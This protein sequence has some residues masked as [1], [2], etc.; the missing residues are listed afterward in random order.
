MEKY[1]SN[2]ELKNL[3][4]IAK[5]T[6]EIVS[7]YDILCDLET[8]GKKDSQSYRLYL[9]NLKNKVLIERDMYA[10]ISKSN[11][12]KYID[13][14]SS[15]CDNTY[16]NIDFMLKNY[17][18]RDF[19][20][21]SCLRIMW[22][23]KQREIFLGENQNKFQKSVLFIKFGL[24][25]CFSIL[26][27]YIDNCLIDNEK[28]KLIYYKYFVSYFSNINEELMFESGFCVNN[29][30]DIS[31]VVNCEEDKELFNI[32]L[33]IMKDDLIRNM[34]DVLKISDEEFENLDTKLK[35][36]IKLLNIRGW[37]LLFDADTVDDINFWFHEYIESDEYLNRHIFDKKYKN[38]ERE[39]IGV[40]KKYN[41]DRGKYLVRKKK[42]DNRF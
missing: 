21:I 5:V 23:L 31:Y 8:K 19:N 26:E 22:K 2:K 16:L 12:I 14:V 6:M 25:K 36:K 17:R 4:D 11:I 35:I 39:I 18:N 38:V 40:F 1:L 34:I 9:E 33:K 29:I 32:Y 28:K 42:N 41:S 27:S 15:N 30:D 3:D 10:K 7:I 37:L 24:S 13:F 20:Y